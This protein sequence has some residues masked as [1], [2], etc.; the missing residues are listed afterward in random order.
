MR[1][2]TPLRNSKLK[3]L[4][5]N[6][7]LNIDKITIFRHPSLNPLYPFSKLPTRQSTADFL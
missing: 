1:M 6:W 4:S 7:V 5:K 2:G 3:F